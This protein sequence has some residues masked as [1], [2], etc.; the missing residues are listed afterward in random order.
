MEGAKEQ[1]F[2]AFPLWHIGFVVKEIE[3]TMKNLYRLGIKPWTLWTFEPP[4]LK[5]A[6][7]HGRKVRHGF[8]AAIAPLGNTAIE[9]LSPLYGE[10]VYA[11]HLEKKGEGFHHIAFSCT[12][13]EQLKDFLKGLKNNGGEIIQ[14]GKLGDTALYF[15]VDVKNAGLIVELFTGQAPT[16]EKKFP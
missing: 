14:S 5:D 13:E 16:P 4:T 2:Y 12:T 15:Y 10:S 8:K 7:V 1:I 6:M 9:L 3:E 11:E